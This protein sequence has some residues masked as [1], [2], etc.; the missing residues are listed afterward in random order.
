MGT[1]LYF[2]NW[3]ARNEQDLV[4]NLIVEAIKMYG[5]DCHYMPRIITNKSTVIDDVKSSKFTKAH[6]IEMYIK[7]VEGFQGQGD[8][9]SKFGVEIRDQMV[10]TIS[11][12]SFTH[13]VTNNDSEITRPREGDLIYFPLNKKF[14][15]VMHVEHESVFYQMGALQTYDLTVELFEYSGEI[16]DTGIPEI[17][18]PFKMLDRSLNSS[19]VPKNI[20][21]IA[22]GGEFATDS[23]G[24]PI[25][26]PIPL[27]L[28]SDSGDGQGENYEIQAESNTY[29]D[30]TEEDPFSEGGRY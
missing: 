28:D 4:E 20:E 1:N 16:V 13:E 5:I 26:L 21:Y 11:R 19:G 30:F 3:D 7:N 2:R 6:G 25:V 14:F 24:N 17:D 23:Q 8:F 29:I 9:L 18:I 15:E 12:R 22:A 27:D 10:L